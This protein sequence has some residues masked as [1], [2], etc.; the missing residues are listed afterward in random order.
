MDINVE[1]YLFT[2][3]KEAYKFDLAT[4]S[5]PALW[6]TVMTILDDADYI[7]EVKRI[8]KAID[9]I[10]DISDDKDKADITKDFLE[11]ALKELKHKVKKELNDMSTKDKD[12]SNTVEEV[13][14]NEKEKLE[15]YFKR[16][17]LDVDVEIVKRRDDDGE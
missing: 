2:L 9:I 7:N 10:R 12:G 3:F 1:K 13:F 15:D 11:S 17:G 8:G 16:I 6:L 5:F 4:L 14:D